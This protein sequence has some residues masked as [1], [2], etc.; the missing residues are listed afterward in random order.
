MIVTAGLV[1]KKNKI[2]TN[3]NRK[4]LQQFYYKTISTQKFSLVHL[5]LQINYYKY[6]IN[7]DIKEN[8][9]TANRPPKWVN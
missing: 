5:L 2:K 4:Q 1:N 9:Q 3:K 8:R 6:T 7:T